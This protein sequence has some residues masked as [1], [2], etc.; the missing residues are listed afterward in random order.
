[1]ARFALCVLGLAPL[2]VLA[3]RAL[4]DELGANPIEAVERF[5]GWWT[6]T[7]LFATLAVTPIRLLTGWSAVTR[8]RRTAGLFA[9]FW[10]C[11]HLTAYVGLDQ[12]FA[13]KD[14]VK[15]VA[16]RPYITVGFTTFLLLLP[17]A[18][19][20]TD[21][22]IRRLG[23]ARWRR[24]HRLVYLAGLGGVLHFFW[25][26]KADVSRPLLYA[27][28]LTLFFAVRLRRPDERRARPSDGTDLLVSPRRARTS[29]RAA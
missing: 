23:G 4:S 2:A 29:R 19:T 21:A 17:L 27:A 9:F 13:L 6:L 8:L 10:A 12:F 24:L 25:L 18:I 20:S 11:L 28:I 16:K 15:D 3:W 1:M 7:L 22:M 5:T 26:V 14:I